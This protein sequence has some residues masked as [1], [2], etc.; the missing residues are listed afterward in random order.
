MSA[1]SQY[2]EIRSK[3]AAYQLALAT[4]HWDGATI[5]PK[6][7]AH[8][9]AQKM[10]IL[11]GEMFSI[12]TDETTITTLENALK[13]DLSF[14]QR[15][16]IEQS[17]KQ[18]KDIMNVPKQTY[19]EFVTLTNEAEHIWE[20]AK[21]QNDYNL[22][23]PYLEKL[24]E[25]SKVIVSYRDSSLPVYEQLLDDFEEGMRIK[26]YDAF[27]SEIKDRLVPFIARIINLSTPAPAFLSAFVSEEEQQKVVAYLAPVFNYSLDTGAIAK[28]VH[29]FSSHFSANDNRVT[30]R[31]LTDKMTSSIFAF[32]HEVG[33]AT[34]NGQVNPEFEGLTLSNSMT[35]GLHESQSRLF[36]NLIGKTKAFWEPH[37]AHI[38][39]LVQ[40]LR[41]VSLDEFI[42]GINFVEHSFIRVEA[43]ELT[44]PLHVLLR[45]E[46]EKALFE[47]TLSVEELPQAWNKK[48][49]DY[50]N[51]EVTRDD[52]GV[53]QDTHWSGAAFGYFPTYA[54][55]S[56][57]GAM[58]FETLNAM[59]DVEEALLA[60]NFHIIKE[61]LKDNIHT[62][63]GLYS[64]KDLINK[65]CSKPFNASA[66]VDGLIRKYSKLYNLT[67][68]T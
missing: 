30:V 34:Y 48:M 68:I 36:E 25:M 41:N 14:V 18:V 8:Y 45:Y 56:A 10:G 12:I 50:L 46:L 29:P 17:L 55:G 15:R 3:I 11:S 2:L 22:F 7:G 62:Y 43:D 54:L 65:V 24:I 16:E 20:T 53:L 26:D 44:Y 38:Q 66:Y 47:G 40:A 42:F 6:A 60:N 61:W 4:L 21:A 35:F 52:L 57:Y 51:L 63:G 32:I 5:A 31:Y 58:F 67:D 28:S 39:T 37:Y 1:Y 19:I 13:E 64:G 9:R 33:H 59:L 23:K 49:K 27:F